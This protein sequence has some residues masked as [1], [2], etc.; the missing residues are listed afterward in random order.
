MKQILLLFGALCF[1]FFSRAQIVINEVDA[2]NPSYDY[3]EYI[4][5]KSDAPNFPLD[6]IVQRK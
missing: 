5:L 6:G 4:E 1:S 3:E 2:D